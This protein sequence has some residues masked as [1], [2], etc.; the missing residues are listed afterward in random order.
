[1]SRAMAVLRS[2][3]GRI[4]L[5]TLGLAGVG[6]L[7]HRASGSQ[8]LAALQAA[9]IY[10]PIVVVLEGCM[11]AC[12]AAGLYLL[13]GEER[14]KLAPADLARAAVVAYPMMVLL[15]VGRA[16]AEAMRAGLLAHKTSGPRAAAAATRMQGVLLLANALISVL[17]AL[18]ALALIGPSILPA[19]I[20]VNT[21]L[22]LG[23]GLSVLYGG[24]RVGLGAWLGRLS[25]RVGR[26]GTQFDDYLRQGPAIP[27]RSV[28]WAFASRLLQLGQY[29]VLLTAVGG[30][31]GILRGLCTQGI[32]LVGSAMGDLI[33]GQLGV[34]EAT[35]SLWSQ[36]LGLDAAAA[37]AI[38]LLAHLAQASWA[39]IG[40][41][42]AL[43]WPAP[44]AAAS[45]T[46]TPAGSP[47]A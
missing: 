18:A 41:L 22:V 37:L 44:P 36:A 31:L 17:C 28:L 25:R 40:S 1:M 29:M 10:F 38:A 46:E 8:V 14:R 5:S 26:S 34:T 47:P 12:E 3:P 35:Y 39:T 23:L 15:P 6:L 30:Q 19:A 43:I 16:A 27:V 11:L 9:A 42:A 24:R 32:H 20:A 21:V 2:L 33:P 4:A 7:I 13:Y 45:P